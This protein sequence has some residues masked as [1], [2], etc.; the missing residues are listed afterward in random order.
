MGRVF[1]ALAT[2]GTEWGQCIGLSICRLGH[3]KL[4]MGVELAREPESGKNSVISP[5]FAELRSANT[6]L[7]VPRGPV[8]IGSV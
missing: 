6:V 1:N 7:C 3:T 5:V 4:T 2:R 8:G